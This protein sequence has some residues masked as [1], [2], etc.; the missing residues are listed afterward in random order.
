MIEPIGLALGSGSARG[1]AHVGVL[2]VLE[3]N[4]IPISHIA[5][6]SI[7]AVFG[8]HYCAFRS[9]EKLEKLVFDISE[10]KLF[11]FLDITIRGGLI[12]GVK[13][14]ALLTDVFKETQ[15]SDLV[16][17]FAAVATDLSNG[18]KV[19]FKS[20]NLIPAIRASISVPALLQPVQF[21]EKVL[22]DGG[23]SD[24]IPVD[25]VRKLGATKVVA[26]NLDTFVNKP[27]KKTFAPLSRVPLNSINILR[28]NLALAT[29]TTTPFIIS[30]LIQSE[31]YAWR[32]FFNP[33]KVKEYI[34]EGERAANTIVPALLTSSLPI[35]TRQTLLQKLLS[36]IR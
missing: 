1:L 35:Q 31:F 26:V 15:F 3:K 34:A 22:G 12:K 7:G 25:V 21:K 27:F 16:I 36:Y 33:L 10:K 28:H 24:P 17:P 32:D 5:G 4:H 30:P 8:A 6:S 20:G 2:K 11:Q 14:E 13:I 29:V 18:S 9:A 19:V 23:L